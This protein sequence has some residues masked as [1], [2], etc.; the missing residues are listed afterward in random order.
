MNVGRDFDLGETA[1]RR[2]FR[3]S[4]VRSTPELAGL[5]VTEATLHTHLSRV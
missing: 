1:A 5:G 2:S 4:P 3:P